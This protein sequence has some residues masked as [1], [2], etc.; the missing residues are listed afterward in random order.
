[1]AQLY[2]YYA[3]MNAGKSTSLLQSAY[4]YTERDMRVLILKPAIDNRDSESEVVSRIGL[5][6]PAITFTKSDDLFDLVYRESLGKRRPDRWRPDAVFVDEAQF[7]TKEHV[8]GLC[9][10]VD[11]ANIPVL[12]YGLRTDFQGN[13]FEG[14]TALMAFAD[15]LVEMKGICHCGKKA[16]MVLRVDKDGNVI[17]D[18]AQIEVGAEDKYVS[19]CRK[20]FIDGTTK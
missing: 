20:H 7:M 8:L 19:V 14:S 4:N 18:G 12:C 11:D 3:S 10:L 9:A 17:R 2:F 1:M 13:L 15:K 16:T 6:A 5:S